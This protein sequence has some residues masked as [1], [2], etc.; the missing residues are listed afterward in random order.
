MKKEAKR[1]YLGP[2]PHQS[3]AAWQRERGSERQRESKKSIEGK[4]ASNIERERKRENKIRT[5][6]ESGQIEWEERS[7]ER[8]KESEAFPGGHWVSGSPLLLSHSTFHSSNL[9]SQPGS[10]KNEKKYSVEEGGNSQ[11][12]SDWYRNTCRGV[13]LQHRF[14]FGLY[15]PKAMKQTIQICIR[16]ASVAFRF[17]VLWIICVSQCLERIKDRSHLILTVHYY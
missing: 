17:L 16:L 5:D 3:A 6:R 8:E 2:A 7:G 15:F 1:E 4:Q 14:G 12:T 11:P 10:R 13:I 9:T